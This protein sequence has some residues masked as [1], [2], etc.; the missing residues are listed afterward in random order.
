MALGTLGFPATQI[1]G[2]LRYVSDFEMD[3]LFVFHTLSL[4]SD[5]IG[6]DLE[7]RGMRNRLLAAVDIRMQQSS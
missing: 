3:F 1:T 2:Y 4:Q 5:V 6:Q 7:P